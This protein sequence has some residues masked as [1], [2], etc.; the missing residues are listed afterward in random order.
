VDG[1]E[2]WKCGGEV[3]Q[4]GWA[5]DLTQFGLATPV[6]RARHQVILL[7]LKRRHS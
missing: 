1:V 4:R 7:A 6:T 2:E 3:R 5:R